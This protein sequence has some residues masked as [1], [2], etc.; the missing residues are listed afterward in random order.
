MPA[1]RDPRSQ[2][3]MPRPTTYGVRF[4]D[5]SMKKLKHLVID[6]GTT[7]RAFLQ[8]LLDKELRRRGLD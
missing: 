1:K 7:L 2:K 4:T 3:G 5:E 6:E 8:A